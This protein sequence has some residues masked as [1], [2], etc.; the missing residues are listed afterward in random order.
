MYIVL[1]FSNPLYDVGERI[2]CFFLCFFI[3]LSSSS[4]S[5]SLIYPSSPFSFHAF[6]ARDLGVF[7]VFTTLGLGVLCLGVLCLGVVGIGVLGVLYLRGGPI[8][9]FFNEMRIFF[10]TRVGGPMSYF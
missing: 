9:C 2:P 4:S 5:C 7:G 1:I 6:H 8:S 10:A 3:A